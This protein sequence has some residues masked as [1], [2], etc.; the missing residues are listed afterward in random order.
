MDHLYYTNACCLEDFFLPLIVVLIAIDL[1]ST[2]WLSHTRC[3]QITRP[4]DRH[5]QTTALRAF[6]PVI[7]NR[8]YI[9]PNK[10]AGREGKK[11][12]LDLVRFR[13]NLQAQPSNTQGMCPENLIQIGWMV[14]EIWLV[15]VTSRGHVYS[16]LYSKYVIFSWTFLG[17]QS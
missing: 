5:H 11:R 2:Q 4:D 14:A 17:D 1:C 7:Q 12:T 3:S 13:W 9:V 8:Y 16:A 10:R 15:K 6:K